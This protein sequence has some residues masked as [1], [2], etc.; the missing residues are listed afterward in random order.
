MTVQKMTTRL[1]GAK[2]FTFNGSFFTVQVQDFLK[3]C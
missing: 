2:K 1:G 3:M